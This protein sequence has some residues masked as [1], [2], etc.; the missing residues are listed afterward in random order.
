MKKAATAFFW[1]QRAL[2]KTRLV[3]WSH[4]QPVFV[5]KVLLEHNHACSFFGWWLCSCCKEQS[6]AAVT[7]SCNTE[8]IYHM[9]LYS[10][11]LPPLGYWRAFNVSHSVSWKEFFLIFFLSSLG[12]LCVSFDVEAFISSVFNEIADKFICSPFVFFPSCV[13]VYPLPFISCFWVAFP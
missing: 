5:N 3:A 12:F 6:W 13:L 11:S 10:T 8:N 2:S 9:L 7:E 4:Q 1:I